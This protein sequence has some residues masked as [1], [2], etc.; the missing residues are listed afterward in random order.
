MRTLFCFLEMSAGGNVVVDI[1]AIRQHVVVTDTA[2]GRGVDEHAVTNIDA[3][4]IDA[5]SA[6]VAEEEQV[7]R[8]PFTVGNGSALGG[9]SSSSAV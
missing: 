3:Y 8:L 1:I 7:A 2:A 9:L 4:V 6:I 5:R